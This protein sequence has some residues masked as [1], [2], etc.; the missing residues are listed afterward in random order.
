MAKRPIFE[1]EINDEKFNAF[2]GRYKQYTDS[3]KSMPGQWDAA[4]Q[5]MG[6]ALL[7]AQEAMTAAE[8]AEAKARDEAATAAK[9]ERD[10]TERIARAWQSASRHTADLAKNVA[11]ATT[12]LLKWSSLSTAFFGLLGTGSLFGLDRLAYTAGAN[13]R[14]AQGLGVSIGEQKAFSVQYGRLVDE[15]KLS[16]IQDAQFD[17]SRRGA[18]AALGVYDPEKRTPADLALQLMDRAKSVYR[19]G[20]SQQ[21]LAATGLSQFFSRAELNRIGAAD[22][23]KLRGA[24]Q[25]D[26]GVLGY[27]DDTARSL[28]DFA[29]RLREAG[30]RIEKIFVKGLQRL[31]ED[32]ALDRLSESVIKLVEALAN[33]P[34]VGKAIDSLAAGL[35]ALADWLGETVPGAKKPAGTVSSPLMRLH[36]RVFGDNA[37]DR[38]T[39][40]AKPLTN[41]SKGYP[42]GV[43]D[44]LIL[45]Q[46]PYG[47]GI[48]G[49]AD[50][51][52]PGNIRIPGTKKFMSYRS[53]EEGVRALDRQLL[54]FEDV[55][56]LDTI[57]KIISRYAPPEENDTA[58]Y[59]RNVAKRTGFGA[60]ERL[61]LHDPDVMAKLISAI[62]KQ[63]DTK[64]D[65]KPAQVRVIVENNTGNNTVVN[66]RQAS[67]TAVGPVY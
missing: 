9:R 27:S 49:G 23:G 21:E 40:G 61:D 42:G 29:I 30:E 6:A 14:S 59:I 12:S 50:R 64:S 4:G 46:N 16:Q 55:H 54:R 47:L 18:F 31:D 60:R 38:F 63:E 66:A 56:H 15:D 44:G 1:I 41:E 36:D 7:A 39:N 8:K 25:N 24:Y 3:L 67:G 34:A 10:E 11:A 52:N 53:D 45:A 19:P 2:M 22:L 26:V 28:Q 32:G 51:H 43:M 65:F 48:F 62:T 5:A 13:R 58:A 37:D 20:M 57:A 35:K 33:S 17:L